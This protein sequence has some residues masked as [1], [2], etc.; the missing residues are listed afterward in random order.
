MNKYL[1]ALK[2]KKGKLTLIIGHTGQGKST[3]T[4][5]I[6]KDSPSLVYDIQNDY[7]THES[8]PSARNA[9]F[10]GLPEDFCNEA[11]KRKNSFIVFEEATSFL[12]GRTTN[13]LRKIMIDKRHKGNNLL[14][15]FHS[16]NSV[17]PRIFELTDYV[18]LF[19]TGDDATAV[20][21]KRA[22]IEPLFFR[23]KKKPDYSYLIFDNI[24]K[25]VIYEK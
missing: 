4:R 20:K 10:I 19:K 12:E 14:F 2:T 11:M 1:E 16:I 18:I 5:T 9:K 21:R 22:E 8:D 17:P 15:L 6:I 7:D 25:N 24:N 13:D 23:L 3:V